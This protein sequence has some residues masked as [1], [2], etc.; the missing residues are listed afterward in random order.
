MLGTKLW[1]PTRAATILKHGASS[2]ALSD[3]SVR[4]V[5]YVTL[6]GFELPMLLPQTPKYLELQV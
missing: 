6:E 3:H 5:H 4:Q 2:V 1:S